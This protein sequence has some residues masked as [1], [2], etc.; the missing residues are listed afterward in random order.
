M[1]VGKG[2]LAVAA[3]MVVF[4]IAGSS[5][6]LGQNCPTSPNYSPDSSSNNGCMTPNGTPANSGF[7][8]FYG[9]A[10]TLIQPTGT[11]NPPQP[12]PSGV[13]TVLRL[14]PDS[15]F[16]SGSSWFSTAQPV[17]A[18]FTTTFTFQFERSRPRSAKQRAR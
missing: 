10:S 14:T 7:P 3:A 15:G 5:T 8:G 12:A 13:T 4:A 6:A 11:P 18:P 9:P 17:G 16:T 1:R 2:M